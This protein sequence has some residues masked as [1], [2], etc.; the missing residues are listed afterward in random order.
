MGVKSSSKFHGFV[1]LFIGL[2]QLKEMQ[3]SKLGM[4]ERGYHLSVEGIRKAYLF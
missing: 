2:Q 4:T 3:S 1:Q